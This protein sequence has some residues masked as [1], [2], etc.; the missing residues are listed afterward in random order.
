MDNLWIIAFIAVLVVASLVTIL[1]RLSQAQQ[2]EMIPYEANFGEFSMPVTDIFTIKGR[3]LVVVGRVES[4]R[5]TT[6]QAVV[7][8]SAEGQTLHETKV[9]GIEQ[10]RAI[11]DSAEA[12]ENVGVL[13]KGLTKDDV[14][15]GMVLTSSN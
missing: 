1:R 6:G 15:K 13:L 3:G 7:I 10:F 5:L 11:V 9:L 8:K 12:G 14:Q 4:G 2:V